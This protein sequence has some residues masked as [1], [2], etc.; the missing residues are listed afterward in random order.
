MSH[1]DFAIFFSRWPLDFKMA[2][3]ADTLFHLIWDFRQKVD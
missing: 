2:A 1:F 3:K